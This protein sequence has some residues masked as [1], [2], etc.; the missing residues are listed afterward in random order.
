M[1]VRILGEGQYEVAD[2]SMTMLQELDLAL[3][4]AIET[5]DEYRF[6][7]ALSALLEFVRTRGKPA[8]ADIL[9]PSDAILPPVDAAMHE[10]SELLGESGE[11]IIP[12]M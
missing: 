10:V 4:Q 12:G 2:E 7:P 5:N 9:Q 8:D 3:E 1:I 11:G 6:R